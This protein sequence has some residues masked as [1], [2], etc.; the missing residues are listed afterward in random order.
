MGP[1]ALLPSD[2][3]VSTS[4]EQARNHK[5]ADDKIELSHAAG[6]NALSKEVSVMLGAG[7]DSLK[8]TNIAAASNIEAGASFKGG[9]GTDTLNITDG[10]VLSAVTGKQFAEFETLDLGD[11]EDTYDL[12]HLASTNTIAS[13]AVNADLAGA[14]TVSNVAEGATIDFGATTT[15]GL[16][17]NQKD[18]GAGS[19]DDV[20]AV[21]ASAKAGVTVASVDLNDIET[22]NVSSMS[23]GTNQTHTFSVL[24]ADEATK[25][26]V[27]ASTAGLTISDLEA[28]SMVLFDASAS[29]MAVS[30]TNGAA[31]TFTAT[32]GV[33]FNMGQAADTVDLTNADTAGAGLEFVVT[34]NGKGDAI[35]LSAAGNVEHVVYKAQSDSTS[36][37]FD[38]VT[39]FAAN[40]DKI[41]IKAFGFTGAADDAVL[42]KNVG[43]AGFSTDTNGD[44]QITSAAAG[45]FFSDGGID[46]AVAEYD[47]GTD[48][49]VFVDADKNGDFNADGDMV[50]KLAGANGAGLDA[51][52]FIFS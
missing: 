38:S 44:V 33:A 35:T 45:N 4:D 21:N 52:D 8:L 30:V 19:P 5:S 47:D 10:D 16:T 48:V 26:T 17:V 12:A 49:W 43:N 9:E 2:Q 14:A 13:V 23:T 22:V 32:S 37:D 29:A 7:D 15:S 40:E 24:A 41:D 36:A 18:A 46:R 34:G 27:D 31:A 39:N 1:L 20:I 3:T 50:I 28:D 11:G 6:A 51:A 42:S 25:V